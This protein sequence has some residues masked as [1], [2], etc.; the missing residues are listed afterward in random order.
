MDDTLIHIFETN[1]DA[2]TINRGFYYQYLRLLKKWLENY[3]NESSEA[4]YSEV[5]DD[6][7]QVGRETTF[8]Q[9]KCYTRDFSFQSNEVTQSLFNYFILFFKKQK[10]DV[11]IIP[12]LRMSVKIIFQMKPY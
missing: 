2:F 6:V 12:Y 10:N 4:I 5:D 3:I 11:G 9:V 8:T 1:T 7:K